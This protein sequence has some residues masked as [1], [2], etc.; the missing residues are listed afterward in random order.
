MLL[1]LRIR[2]TNA[3]IRQMYIWDIFAAFASHCTSLYTST[4]GFCAQKALR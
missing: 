3:K 4:P 1:F 2:K